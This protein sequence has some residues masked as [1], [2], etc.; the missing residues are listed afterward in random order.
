MPLILD[1]RASAHTWKHQI[2]SEIHAAGVAGEP[3]LAVVLVGGHPASLSY[4][5][6]KQKACAEVGIESRLIRLDETVSQEALLETVAGL[7]RDPAVHGVLVQLPLPQSIDADRVLRAVDPGKDVDGFHPY[8]LGQLVAGAPIFVP[9]TPL[10]IDRLVQDY[11]ICLEGRSVVIVGRSR[12]VGKPLALLWSIKRP[13]G[14]PTV[15][16]AHSGTR[17]LAGV[18]RQADVLVIAAGQRHL[19]GP[20]YVRPGAVVI[21]VGIHP[22]EVDGGRKSLTGDVAFDQVQP[23]CSAIT[24]VPGGV[25]PMTVAA[26]LHNTWLAFQRQRQ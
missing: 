17:D 1:G 12:I 11:G 22:I 9:C 7:N 2:K 4:V 21:D 15:T 6:H 19:I 8:N 10:G 23:L 18:C 20:D 25:G 26:L 14:S 16:L 24:P 3:C 5:A 13:G